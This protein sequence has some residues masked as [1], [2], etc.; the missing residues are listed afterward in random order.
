MAEEIRQGHLRVVARRAVQLREALERANLRPDLPFDA[1]KLKAYTHV[2]EALPGPGEAEVIRQIVKDAAQQLSIAADGN[3]DEEGD[4][5]LLAIRDLLPA[6]LGE[7]AIISDR[8][9]ANYAVAGP[10][11]PGPTVETAGLEEPIAELHTSIEKLADALESVGEVLARH[12]EQLDVIIESLNDPQVGISLFGLSYSRRSSL[13]Q[14]I[15]LRA[16]T[17]GKRISKPWLD[18]IRSGTAQ[19]LAQFKRPF[20]ENR[21]EVGQVAGLLESGDRAVQ[22]GD[23]FIEHSNKLASRVSAPTRPED[24]PDLASFRELEFAPEMVVIPGGTFLMGSPEDEPE[25]Q[26]LEG[27]QHEVTV[28]RFALGRYA[29]TVGEFRRFA[30]ETGHDGRGIDVWTGSDWEHKEDASWDAPGFEQG[31]DHPVAGVS[32]NDAQAYLEWLNGKAGH[33]LYRLPSE[34]E[35]EYACRAGSMGPFWW[36]DT[37]SPDQANYRGTVAYNDGATGEWRQRTV[38]VRSFDANPFGL[39]Q[40]HGNVFEWCADDWHGNYEG[41][42]SDG[43]A[44]LE[45]GDRTKVLRGGSWYYYPRDLR[46][47]NRLR[48]IPDHRNF[49]IGFRVARTLT[50]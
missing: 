1:E 47:A 50:P 42:P 27:P 45:G 16:Q 41:A 32:W 33:N 11:A 31:E 8:T 21:D 44:W 49:I 10:D 13:A 34:A 14:A 12:G 39:W 15:E 3:I 7:L 46:S 43:S 5:E 35:W 18:R 20:V 2:M 6:L 29:V 4:P 26:S 23:D 37:I 9:D 24:L 48:N 40:M 22:A 19:S 17:T 28:P 36:G 25:R 38:P 30:E